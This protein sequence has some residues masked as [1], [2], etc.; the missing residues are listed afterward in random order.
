MIADQAFADPQPGAMHGLRPQPFGGEELQHLAGA[1][2][3]G[4]ADLGH[5]VGG[6]DAHDLVEPLLRRA[7]T[8]P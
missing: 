1:H 4:R 2:D 5:H 8:R 6:D 3:I 7:A